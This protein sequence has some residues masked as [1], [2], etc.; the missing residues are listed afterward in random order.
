LKNIFWC[1]SFAW[2]VWLYI[3][4]RPL[5][6]N[7]SVQHL[8]I[9]VTFTSVIPADSHHT[10]EYIWMCQRSSHSRLWWRKRW[11]YRAD[12]LHAFSK[13]P[14][15]HLEKS[16]VVVNKSYLW[17]R[18]LTYWFGFFLCVHF[19][20]APHILLAISSARNSFGITSCEHRWYMI[21]QLVGWSERQKN[22]RLNFS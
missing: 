10:I 2:Y 12:V 11:K 8:K 15:I 1:F 18:S 21:G 9:I 13:S 3:F 19:D 5:F 17:R 6:S 22:R 7:S 16:C 14:D 4:H 20:Q